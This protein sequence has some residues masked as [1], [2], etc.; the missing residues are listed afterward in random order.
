MTLPEFDISLIALAAIVLLAGLVRGFSGFGTGMIVM[1]VAAALYG[2]RV[3]IVIILVIDLLPV[4][5]VTLPAFRIAHWR[6][7]LPV[8]AGM[9]FLIPLGVAILKVGDPLILRWLI[10]F[11]VFA[12]VALLFSGWRYRGPR[13]APVS[14]AVGGIAGLLGGIA[15]IPGPPP[16]L[17]WMASGLAPAL[18]RANM[19]VLLF[20]SDIISAG[21]VWAAGLLTGHALKLGFVAAPVYFIGLTGGWLLFPLASEKAYRRI[22]FTVIVLSTMSAL[23]LFDRLYG[24]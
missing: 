13:G 1:P 2:P 4:I 17:Y 5:P 3:A 16:I 22:A 20:L 6:E 9:F 21:N 23:P 12:A 18:V 15:A 19:M 11:V 8:L 24:G 14:F 7:I 10:C